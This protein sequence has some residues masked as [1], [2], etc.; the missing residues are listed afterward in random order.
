MT[1]E[2]DAGAVFLG[3]LG[4]VAFVVIITGIIAWVFMLAWN[5]FMVPVFGLPVIDFWTAFAGWVLIGFVGSAFRSVFSGSSS[6]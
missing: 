1:K 6:R 4:V 5:A 2:T 3:C